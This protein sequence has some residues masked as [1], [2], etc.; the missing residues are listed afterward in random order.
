MLFPYDEPGFYSFWMKGMRFDIDIVWLREGRIVDLSAGVPAPRG[1]SRFPTYRPRELTDAVLEVPAGFS[2]AHGWQIGD[3]A[4]IE[5]A[6]PPIPP[7]S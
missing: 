7:G 2:V 1:S 3:L 6:P 4:R 5:H